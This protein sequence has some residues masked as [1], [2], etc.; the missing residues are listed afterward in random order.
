MTEIKICIKFT[1]IEAHNFHILPDPVN[2]LRFSPYELK[3]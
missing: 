2:P 1:L 3:Q